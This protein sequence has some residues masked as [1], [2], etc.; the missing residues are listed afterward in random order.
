[1]PSIERQCRMCAVPSVA[2]DAAGRGGSRGWP[3]QAGRGVAASPWAQRVAGSLPVG[4][5]ATKAVFTRVRAP[6]LRERRGA[7]QN[8]NGWAVAPIYGHPMGNGGDGHPAPCHAPRV[9]GKSPS[10]DLRATWMAP[11]RCWGCCSMLH[12]HAAEFTAGINI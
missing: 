7:T 4:A 9:L 2:C 6:A 8:G 1:M 11:G 10:G 3:G 5:A 12:S